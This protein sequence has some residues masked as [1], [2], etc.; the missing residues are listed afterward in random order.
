MLRLLITSVLFS[1]NVFAESKPTV[2]DAN[3]P[4][5]KGLAAYQKHDFEAARD[6]F[7]EAVEQGPVTARLLHNLALAYYQTNQRAYA[8]AYWRKALVADPRYPAALTGRELLETHMHMRP[9]ETSGF[10][11]SVRHALEPVSGFLTSWALAVLIAAF[12][13]ATL[14]F[15]NA[16]R[17]ARDEERAGP[18]LPVTAA[19][20]GILMLA[21]AGVLAL[22]L[23]YELHPRATVVANQAGAKSLP[24]PESATLFELSSGGEVLVKRTDDAWAQVQTGDGSV[25]WVKTSDIVVTSEI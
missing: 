15:L 12:A 5:Q 25:G 21:T 13:W 18:G 10:S 23:T 22:K 4:F 8:L 11:L 14:R 17:T 16:R 20:L 9:F 3:E 1:L 2:E 19:A 24:T 7:R 6:R